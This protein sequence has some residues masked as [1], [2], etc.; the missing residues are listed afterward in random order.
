LKVADH[1]LDEILDVVSKSDDVKTALQSVCTQNMYIKFFI[2]QACNDIWVDFDIDEINYKFND[3]HRSM[4]G[5]RLLSKS[6]YS[7][8]KDVLLNPISIQKN[9]RYQAKNLLEMLYVGEAKILLS[10]F[11]KNLPELYPNITH[12]IMVASL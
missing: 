8:Y 11:K 2:D 6:A 9:K 12:E 4:A 1:Q 3:Y 5:N 7:I 10:V